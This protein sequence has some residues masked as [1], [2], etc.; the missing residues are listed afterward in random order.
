VPAAAPLFPQPLHLTRVVETPLGDRTTVEEYL[1]GNRVITVTADRTVILDYDKQTMTEIGRTTYSITPFDELARAQQAGRRQG[2]ARAT[3]SVDGWDVR[4][5]SRPEGRDRGDYA[6]A[7]PASNAN[8]PIME[9]QVGV[10]PTIRLSREAVEVL[11]GATYP[12]QETT[13]SAIALRAI[14]RRGGE[15]RMQPLGANAAAENTLALPIEHSVTYAVDERESV[16]V[17]NRVTRIGNEIVPP[18]AIAIP[19]GAKLVPSPA[20]ETRRRLEELDRFA[21]PSQ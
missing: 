9:V 1:S 16:V 12:Q 8:S 13:A 6:I 5:A 19:P 18:A 14:A 17:R 4:E 10:D 15:R 2:A 3:A 7:R 21:P 11:L 20:V